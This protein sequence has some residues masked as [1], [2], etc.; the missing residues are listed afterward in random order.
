MKPFVLGASTVLAFLLKEG[1]ASADAVFLKHL[2]NG[3][4]AH[5]PTLWHLE[6]RNVL[7]LK[8]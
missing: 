1:S 7:F 2:A 4:T 8:E 5:V 3:A 6:I